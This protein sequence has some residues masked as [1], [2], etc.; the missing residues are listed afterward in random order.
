MKVAYFDCFAGASGDMLLGALV[1]AGLPLDALKEELSKLSLRGYTLLA[2][3]GKRGPIAGTKVTVELDPS[4]G[5]QP[6]RTINDIYEII[7]GSAIPSE[8]AHQG[9]DIFLRL[10]EAEAKIHGISPQEVHFHEVGAVDSIVDIMGTLLGLRLLGVAKVYCSP[11][12]LGDGYVNAQHGLLPVPAPATLELIARAKAPTRPNPETGHPLGEML[13]P[14]AAAILTTLATFHR[15]ALA[16]DRV[17]YGL[18]TRDNPRLPNALRLWLGEESGVAQREV[19]LLETNIDDMNPEIYGYVLERLFSAGAYDVW[20]TPIQMKKNRPG[21]MMSVLAPPEAEAT[22][23]ELV[24]RETSTLGVRVQLLSRYEAE[25]QVVTVETELGAAV[26]KAKSLHGHVIS[27]SPEYEDCRRL[28]LEHNIPIGQVYQIVE[29]EAWA[30]LPTVG[31][32]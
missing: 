19:L 7:D 28:A 29:K 11:L 4:H 8:L 30:H 13:T 12:P 15:P 9:K 31:T 6:Q 16:L 18:G 24:L 17:G 23:A 14:T 26:V 22:V 25:R 20:F 32:P 27:I 5:Q 2:Q 21:T 3:G 10:A 1:D